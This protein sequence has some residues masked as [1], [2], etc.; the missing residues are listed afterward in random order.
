MP[1]YQVELTRK[2]YKQ[3]KKLPGV[4]QDLVDDALEA[5]ETDGPKPPFWDVKKIADGYR[6]RI[7]Y[8]YRMR[9]ILK[10]QQLMIEIFYIG[11]RKDAY[12]D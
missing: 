11:H 1:A 2:A 6:L 9:Y 4:V 12:S 3:L 7:N 8:R 10:Q 5:L